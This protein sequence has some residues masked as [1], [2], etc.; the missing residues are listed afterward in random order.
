[1]RSIH[2]QSGPRSAE[3]CRWINDLHEEYCP[4]HQHHRARPEWRRR[5]LAARAAYGLVAVTDTT[6]MVAL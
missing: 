4:I 1:M 2:T 3:P 5:A 6:G